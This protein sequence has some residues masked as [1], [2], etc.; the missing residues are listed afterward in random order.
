MVVETVREA[1]ERVNRVPIEQVFDWK[2]LKRMAVWMF[3]LALLPMILF[4]VGYTAV[5]QTNPLTD[6]LPRFRDVGVT[7]VR[8]N[9]MLQD[10]IWP[11]RAYLDVLDFPE[12]GEMRIGRDAP[13]P[14]LRFK[15]RRWVIA[16]SK[17]PEGWRSLTWSDLRADW[18]DR[19]IP[20]FPTEVLERKLPA[21]ARA[22]SLIAAPGMV[23]AP[24]DEIA[25]S[26][27][28]SW[29]LDRV[30]IQLEDETNQQR[31]QSQA[32]EAYSALAS[33][34]DALTEAV[35]Q[36]HLRSVIRRLEV[37][38]RIEVKY[39]GQETS[40]RLELLRGPGWE[41]AGTLGDLK[42]SVKFRARGA[43]YD[44]PTRTITLVPPPT[45]QQL[46]RIERR[47]AYQFHRPPLGNPPEGGPLAL[48]G[49]RQRVEDFVSLNGPTSRISVPF[50]S[51]LVLEGQLDKELVSATL[52]TRGI[53]DATNRIEQPMA[54]S[55]DRLNFRQRFDRV[56]APLDFDL[57][58]TDTD[59]VKSTRHIIVE[60]VPDQP[61]IVNVIIDGIRKNAQGHYM[62]TPQAMIPFEGK[63]VDG[64]G[65]QAGGLD[66]IEYALTVTRMESMLITGTQAEWLATAL[67]PLVGGRSNVWFSNAVAL[68]EVSRVVQ[69]NAPLD[70]ERHIPLET[71]Q[72]LYRDRSAGDITRAELMNRLEREPGP[73]ALIRD[74]VLQPRFE[75]LDLR[76]RMPE[77]KAKSELE[78]QPRYRLKLTV[79]ATDNNVETGP[80]VAANKEPPFIVLVVS[81]AELLVEIARE[82]ENL[83]LKAEDG[84]QRLREARQKLDKVAEEMP[85]VANDQLTTLAQRGQEILDTTGK[86]RDIMQEVLTDYSR[87]LR[88]LE[89]NRAA[90]KIIEKVKVEICTP[91]DSALKVEFVNAEESLEAYR[92][93]L[94]AGRRPDATMTNRA[95]T[96]LDQL[97]EK[98]SQVLAS[99][100][101]VTTINKLI[102]ALREIEKGQEQAIGSQLKELQ[103]LKREQLIKELEKLKGL[104]DK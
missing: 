19:E 78:V 45:I 4:G 60:A 93:E 35:K 58:F 86:A 25:A 16:D 39:W 34:F 76:E 100:G 36:P 27:Q 88:E 67:M 48:R 74:F 66:R 9:I 10:V 29:T 83:H 63:V 21:A 6:Y 31:I 98:L 94:E 44:T 103:R 47:P 54:L 92:K 1:G 81:E 69:A 53:S 2:R 102:T 56:T 41:Y 13:S 11:R 70:T 68:A 77:L 33:M 40:N 97:I 79:I 82:E 22:A 50:G 89:L 28:S 30:E 80:G 37:P 73:S 15:A 8:R 17:A 52:K 71:F 23:T 91:L 62:V 42:E 87:I 57:D 96:R 38:D 59:G 90:A 46:K 95:K 65:G 18:I 3:G 85:N 104:E 32:P 75:F 72:Q 43:D 14:R 7:W 61:P 49:L 20:A 99:M 84:V 51:E 64:L 55:D 101:D 24:P 5:K 12:S 26:N